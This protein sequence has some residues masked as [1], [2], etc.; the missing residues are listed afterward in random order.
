MPLRAPL[1]EEEGEG[2]S[3]AA[4]AVTA[5]SVAPTTPYSEEGRGTEPAES[6]HPAGAV[7]K[8]LSETAEAS[9][10][11][12]GVAVSVA[13]RSFFSR[14]FKRKAKKK[15]HPVDVLLVQKG[16]RRTLANLPDPEGVR[17]GSDR[18]GNV[19]ASKRDENF[20]EYIQSFNEGIRYV[21][22]LDA[23]LQC[24]KKGHV[25]HTFSAKVV[26]LSTTGALIKLSDQASRSLIE[27]SDVSHI[28]FEITPGALPEGLEMKVK[29]KFTC[30]R[31][32]ERED[33][34]YAGIQFAVPL[35]LYAKRRKDRIELSVASAMLFVICSTVML[36]RAESIIYF[37]FNKWL[38]LYSI[39]AMVFLL[40]RY[41]L[42]ALY[43]P[44]PID[45][46]YTPSVT[47]IIP[48]F[49]EEQ[50]IG[51]TIQSCVNQDYP[52]DKLEVFVVD[53]C[54]D[55]RSVE[56]AEET[57][58]KLSQGN[59]RFKVKER[60][61][62][63]RAE[64]NG[65]KREAICLGV[66]QA[67]SDLVVFVDSDSFL[68]VFAIRHIVQPFKDPKMGGVSGRTDVENTY[69]NGLTRMQSVRYYIA[70]RI[71]KAAEAVFDTVTCLSGPLSC[72]R[73]DIVMENLDAWRNQ[74]FLGQRATFGD[75]RSMTNRVLRKYR[76]TYQD[77]AVCSTI[78]PNEYPVFLK[79]QMR[80]KR[81]WLRES[82]VAGKFMWRKEPF[83]AVLFY[84]GMIVPIA[85]PI[86]VIYNLIYVPIVHRVFPTT[87]LVGILLMSLLMSAAQ[88][89]LRKSSTWLWG[90][91]F[92]FYYEAVLLWQMPYAWVTFWKSTWGTRMTPEDVK[93]AEKKQ[94]QQ[95]KKQQQHEKAMKK[96]ARKR[97]RKE[98]K[99]NE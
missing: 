37:K 62:V 38:Y 56:V 11:A 61:H 35:S 65:G 74:K 41:L 43:K 13:K 81:S 46:N 49:N 50:W 67:K 4:E 32:F 45:V 66:L 36:M 77:S 68:D 15:K 34:I 5:P 83:S 76:T 78:V 90:M 25:K 82:M 73:R 21:V 23:K 63:I 58:E 64:K 97:K 92:C 3:A 29:Q 20:E 71:M 47:I 48:C 55:D 19:D 12:A 8:T 14:I 89:L 60:V 75:D 57:I 44:V 22:D 93:A 42:G 10:G 79:Q 94:Q 84:I 53:D 70:F 54:S 6:A 80:W 40:S 7:D 69:T 98:G 59:S 87:F 9:I 51:R 85:A 1:G 72:Y 96:Q 31:V 28:N 26:D 99:S 30:A 33:G 2:T 16:D 27:E 17:K 86:V 88:M 95:D 39:L 52:I 18:R 24:Y 91:L